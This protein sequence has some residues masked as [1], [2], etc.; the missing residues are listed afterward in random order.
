MR[1]APDSGTSGESQEAGLELAT[2]RFGPDA[3][4]E[5]RHRTLRESDVAPPPAAGGGVLRAESH[6][7]PFRRRQVGPGAGRLGKCSL[8]AP[9]WP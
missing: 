9:K 3:R 5:V 7:T 8:E 4:E 1:P 2:R 6:R